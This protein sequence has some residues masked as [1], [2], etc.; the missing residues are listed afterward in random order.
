LK[1]L[2]QLQLLT[3]RNKANGDFLEKQLQEDLQEKLKSDKMNE[4]GF[5]NI[6]AI[7][8]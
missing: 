6:A 3:E 1:L 2:K 4:I 5:Y 7:D 8:P